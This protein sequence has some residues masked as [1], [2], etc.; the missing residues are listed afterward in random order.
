MKFANFSTGFI[1]FL[2]LFVENGGSVCVIPSIELN[3][4]NYNNFLKVL[5]TDLIKNN[6]K[7]NI[8]ISKINNNHRIFNN[9]FTKKKLDKD[10]F[11]PTQ[12]NI[13]HWINTEIQ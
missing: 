3:K 4:D 7:T 9:V 6:I 10:I 1:N 8:K 12:I 13:I 5:E 11:L 2:N